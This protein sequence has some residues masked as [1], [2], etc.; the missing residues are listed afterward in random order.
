MDEK[1]GS[2]FKPV[3]SGLVALTVLGGIAL[4]IARRDDAGGEDKLPT[5]VEGGPK[6]DGTTL[7][8][9]ITGEALSGDGTVDLAD[10]R[11][12]PVIVNVWASWCGPCRDEAPDIKRFVAERTDVV[13]LG[14]NVD[15]DRKAAAAFN[16]D[17][18]WTHPSIY[19]PVGKVSYDALRVESLP[20]TIYIDAKG[21]LRGRSLAPITFADLVAVADRL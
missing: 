11:G 1:K 14:V 3:L 12:K 2:W 19:D 13:F 17:V 6:L 8:T 5:L 16:R 7:A 10:Y 18:K 21:V 20:A 15:T 4:G 9:G